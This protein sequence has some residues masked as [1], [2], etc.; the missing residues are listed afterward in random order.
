MIVAATLIILGA[1][2]A[3]FNARVFVALIKKQ[4]A[5]SWLPLIGGLAGAVG[6]YMLPLPWARTFW[7]IPLLLDWG[8]I[9]G[10][11]HAIFW[12]SRRVWRG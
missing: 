1:W 7:W 10:L 6:V 3:M 11:T 12:H 2:I 5:P 9:P 8:S 4:P